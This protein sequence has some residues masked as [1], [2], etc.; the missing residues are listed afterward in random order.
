MEP[1]DHWTDHW[2]I[3]A[4]IGPLDHWTDH[5]TIG[6]APLDHCELFLVTAPGQ[7]VT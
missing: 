5:W 4:T 1:L 7:D 3:G 2:T 6:R